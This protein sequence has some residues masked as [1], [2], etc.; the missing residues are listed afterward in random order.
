MLFG[1]G[2]NDDSKHYFSIGR[3]N[4]KDSSPICRYTGNIASAGTDHI[5]WQNVKVG[6][7][8]RKIQADKAAD[9]G[10]YI[11]DEGYAAYASD[12]GGVLRT[13]LSVRHKNIH[14][15][16]DIRCDHSIRDQLCRILCGDIQGRY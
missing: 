9:S 7:F 12:N 10:V 2:I 13:V 6:A 15:I 3:G 4:V 16:S 5:V 11:R 1:G 14:I 8:R